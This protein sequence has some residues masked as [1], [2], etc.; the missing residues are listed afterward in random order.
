MTTVAPTAALPCTTLEAMYDTHRQC[1]LAYLQRRCG[2]AGLAEDL[3]AETFACAYISLLRQPPPATP[4]PWL[5]GIAT[6]KLIDHWRR[7]RRDGRV[8]RAVLEQ[9]HESCQSEWLF[10]EA[11]QSW[12][13]LEQLEPH[14]REALLLRYCEELSVAEVAQRLDRSVH[15]TESL[16]ARARCAFRK[17]YV[18]FSIR[19]TEVESEQRLPG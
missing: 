10:I 2:H 18:N 7:E 8:F 1:V 13:V 16:L 19:A 17:N 4:L 12:C 14:Y 15:S 3:A 11:G 6:H 9:W 5:L